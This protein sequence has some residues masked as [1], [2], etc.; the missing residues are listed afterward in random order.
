VIVDA[1][2]INARDCTRGS[3]RSARAKWE[4]VDTRD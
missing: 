3:L 4:N 1:R 2:D